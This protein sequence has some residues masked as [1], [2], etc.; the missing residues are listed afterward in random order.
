MEVVG[1]H[2]RLSAGDAA[3]IGEIVLG[4]ELHQAVAEDGE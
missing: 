4:G 2:A 1:H 3:Q